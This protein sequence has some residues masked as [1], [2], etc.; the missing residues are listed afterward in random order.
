MIKKIRRILPIRQKISLII[1]AVLLFIGGIFDLLGVS[2]IIP[3]V[4]IVMDSSIIEDN[5]S[6]TLIR[7]VLGIRSDKMFIILLLIVMIAVYVLKN[8]YMILMYNT[9]YNI[10]WKYKEQ[11]S[12]RLLSCYMYQDYTFHLSKNV[13]DLQRNILTDVGQFYGFIMDLLNMFNQIVVCTLIV[14]Y[15]LLMDCITT[16]CVIVF[17]GGAILV[18]Y[19]KQKS[20]QEERG[21]V[22]RESYAKLNK[23]IL[24]SF[25]GIKEIQVL[26]R[27][28]FFLNRCKEEY[29]R[30]MEANK[31]SNLASL[32]PKPIMETVCV[33]GLLSI[34]LIRLLFG[35]DVSGFVPI[36]AVLA[37]SAFRMLPCFNSISAY[38]ATM[39]FEKDSVNAVFEDINEMEILEQKRKN[40][41]TNGDITFSDKIQI[42]NLSY[43]YPDTDRLILKSVDF[44]ILKNQSVGFVGASGA[45]KSTL[46]DIILGVLPIEKGKILIDG[47]D[48][49]TNLSSWHSIIGY[50][51]QTI[52]LMDDSIR[53][54]V[55]LGVPE[56]EISD[57]ELWKALEEAQIADFVRSLPNGIYTEIGDRGV[58]ISGGQRQRLGIARAL[59]HKP[60]VLIFDEAT[61]ALDN[62]TEEALM[63]A[64]NSLKG[65]RTMLIIAHRLHTIENCDVI[66]EVENLEVKSIEIKKNARVIQ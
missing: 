44:K 65:R 60:E 11:L 45:G 22:S 21:K 51:P 23:W 12:M 43:K 59:Y 17:L 50:I 28:E 53:N 36:L 34:V 61:S 46:I 5:N 16:V 1:L 30:G 66:Y 33:A 49:N 52:Y 15:L 58:R 7:D 8:L 38:I 47:Q 57:D 56:N 55:A 2:L 54:N 63:E 39:M 48:I 27:E 14:I 32:L 42:S 24:Q 4:N 18:I 10:L 35:G 20:V 41:L 64:I 19:K 31:K 40:R 25:A 26:G 3:I 29:I 9:M 6:L 62:D 13:S 37:V